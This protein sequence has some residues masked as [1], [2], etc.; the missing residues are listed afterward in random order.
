MD[1]ISQRVA[2]EA[3]LYCYVAV[4]LELSERDARLLFKF[5]A[6]PAHC[7]WRGLDATLSTDAKSFVAQ[8][9]RRLLAA[10]VGKWNQRA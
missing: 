4:K 3:A 9:A 1:A 10:A 5:L 6:V 7:L 8:R 2:L